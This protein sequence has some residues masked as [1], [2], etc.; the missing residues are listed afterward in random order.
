MIARSNPGG[1]L[2]WSNSPFGRQNLVYVS[3]TA[4]QYD[5][6][7]CLPTNVNEM[8][9][10]GMGLALCPLWVS[11]GNMILFVNFHVRMA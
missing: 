6:P 8:C 1:G 11:P 9:S 10:S 5:S 4:V 7:Y 3:S 2:W